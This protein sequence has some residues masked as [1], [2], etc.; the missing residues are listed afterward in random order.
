LFP[1][2]LAVPAVFTLL[3][4]AQSP[5]SLETTPDP[6]PQRQPSAFATSTPELVA[7][8]AALRASRSS[9]T[10]DASALVVRIAH[11]GPLAL[12]AA[13]E[14][15]VQRSVPEARADDA[16]Q[17]LSGPQR[18]LVLQ[19]I[20]LL[21]ITDVRAHLAVRLRAARTD[22]QAVH[23]AVVYVLGAVGSANDLQ[24]LAALAPRK[25]EDAD[26]LTR[27]ARS[28]LTEGAVAILARDP[29]A[30]RVI[31]DVVRTANR[32]AARCLIEAVGARRDPRA[33][34][35]LY[36]AVSAHPDLSPLAVAS[37]QRVGPSLDGE[38][39]LQFT[40]W[41]ASEFAFA[42]KESR[43][44]LLQAIGVLD[45]GSHAHVLV[46][47]LDDEEFEVREAAAWALRKM[48]GFG[49]PATPEPWRAWLHDEQRWND[50]ERAAARAALES[51]DVA[52]V[53]VA[54]RAYAG[55]RAWRESLALD[56]ALVLERNEPNLQRLACEVLQ[57]LNAYCA[58]R[59]MASLLDAPQTAVRDAARR[60]L[61][62]I[63]GLE[64]P[65]D[66]Q[67][68]MEALNLL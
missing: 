46:D 63:T 2:L 39:T 6:E 15:L 30:W 27:D 10:S 24:R 43:Q 32:S 26:V 17:T 35:I 55:R 31:D 13:F 34:E 1:T 36:S 50:D 58:I 29:R 52:E 20:A 42:R 40:S 64:L 48:T 7:I 8:G 22:A 59:P 53:V 9:P 33:L 19:A 67:L 14:V 11:A 54:L 57:S 60:A 28:A 12:E 47:A 3:I 61:G 51:S 25:S 18:A 37:V 68:A 62:S 41:M 38:V 21:P 44:G 65:Q 56:V 66:A 4:A 49:Y 45:D 16:S 5:A 23:L